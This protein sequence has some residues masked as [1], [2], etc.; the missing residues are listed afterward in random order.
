MAL[1]ATD[2]GATLDSTSPAAAIY[3][4]TSLLSVSSQEDVKRNAE[5]P[6]PSNVT[7]AAAPEKS[8]SNNGHYD[9]DELLSVSVRRDA[10][11]GLLVSRW[12][13]RSWSKIIP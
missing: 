7:S 8:D 2:E 13:R 1:G 9:G 6:K 11:L 12:W 4:S 10:R 5:S 3:A